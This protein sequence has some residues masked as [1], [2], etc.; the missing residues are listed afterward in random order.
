MQ[1]WCPVIPRLVLVTYLLR[2]SQIVLALVI[3]VV[4]RLENIGLRFDHPS[5]LCYSCALTLCV[6]WVQERSEQVDCSGSHV[7]GDVL[8]SY[9]DH[10][11]Y[12]NHGFVVE[13]VVV[14]HQSALQ[15]LM[16]HP[17]TGVSAGQ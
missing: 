12:W 1:T 15:Y 13:T 6:G 10:G 8:Y 2:F 17:L 7:D 4:E 16:M 11:G 3:P 9:F 14:R 5:T